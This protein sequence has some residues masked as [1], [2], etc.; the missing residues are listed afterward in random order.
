MLNTAKLLFPT[1][2]PEI[3]RAQLET[4]QVNLGYLCNQTCKHCHVNAGPKRTE[5][6]H[7]ETMDALLAFIDRKGVAALDL[8]GGAPELNPDFRYLV[9]QVRRRGVRVMD[10]CNLTVLEEPGQESLADFLAAQQ[11]EIVA[12]LPCYLEE[13]V[14]NQRG[15]GVFEASIAGLKRLNALGYGREGSGLLLN[16]VFNPQGA[17]LPPSQSD[18]EADY[19]RQLFEKYGI[20]FN[21]LFTI[22]N[23]PI[24]RFGS[25]LLSKGEFHPYMQ[26]LKESYSSCNLATVMCRNL[27]S[28][29]WQG[30]VYD[31]D[32]NQMLGM[33]LETDGNKRPHISDLM[34]VDLTMLPIKTA[35]HCYGCTAGQGSS[36]GGALGE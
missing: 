19:K 34:E 28:V 17:T 14:D 4:L 16:L 9:E 22:T 1:T 13:N 23:M 5:L 20:R 7:R 33:H 18:L 2:F 10:R 12:S 32:F 30:Y 29:D 36:C 8:T 35:E 6:M 15:K 31:C 27:I 3:N 21:Q 24:S 26:L 25:M 11:V